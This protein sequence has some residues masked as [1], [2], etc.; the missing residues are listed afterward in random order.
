M[1]LT[2]DVDKSV[3][4]PCAIRLT[5]EYNEAKDDDVVILQVIF[6]LVERDGTMHQFAIDFEPAEMIKLSEF[7]RD[8]LHTLVELSKEELRVKKEE[9][10]SYE[11]G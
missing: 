6:V 7:F 10:I 9:T 4:I 2:R 8:N 11:W 3:C 1:F 5:R